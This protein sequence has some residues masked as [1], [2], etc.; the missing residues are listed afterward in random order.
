M[1]SIN[2]AL[3]RTQNENKALESKNSLEKLSKNQG[4]SGNASGGEQSIA[5]N[6]Q[7]SVNS[8]GNLTINNIDPNDEKNKL[9][10]Q[11]QLNK[12]KKMN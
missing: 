3:M 4:G 2:E 6:V 11:D 7:V 5:G 10:N 8:S 1:E 12:K 9:P